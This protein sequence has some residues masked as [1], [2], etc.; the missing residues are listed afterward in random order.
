MNPIVWRVEHFEEVDSTN[1][2]L[3]ERAKD[4]AGDG[5]VVYADFQ[6]RGRG[7]LDR[8]WFAPPGTSLLCSVLLRPAIEVS[9]LHLAVACVALATRAALVR[10]CGVRPVLKWPNDLLVGDSKLA[11]LLAEYVSGAEP[12]VVVG[13]GVNLLP[14]GPGVVG[15]TSVFEEARVKVTPRALLDILLEELEPRA[16]GLSSRAG[17]ADLRDEYRGALVTIGH[18]VRVEHH[19]GQ[20][21]GLATDVDASGRLVLDT[22]DETV[23]FASGDVVHLRLDDGTES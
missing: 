12:A 5:T 8:T 20:T 19:A 18:R 23:V 14:A 16:T 2:W 9:D 15:S 6:T 10:L 7:R 22:G 21:F 11:G 17:R 3:V 1:S 4:G 13:I